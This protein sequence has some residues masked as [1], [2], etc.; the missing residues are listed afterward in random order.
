[1]KVIKKIFYV[2]I[3]L[4]II[5]VFM[6]WKM[7]TLT[8]VTGSKLSALTYEYDHE[9]LGSGTYSCVYMDYQLRIAQIKKLMKGIEDKKPQIVAKI[10]DKGY[11]KLIYDGDSKIHELKEREPSS[12]MRLFFG[13]DDDPL[14]HIHDE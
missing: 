13:G 6:N 10:G 14:R 12:F 8:F 11:Q 5:Y 2:I 9:C 7:L 3:A 1:M 4:A